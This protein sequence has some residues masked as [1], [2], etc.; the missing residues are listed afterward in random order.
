MQDDYAI[1][2]LL[3]LKRESRYSLGKQKIDSMLP[4]QPA[5]VLLCQIVV[6]GNM[7]WF[8]M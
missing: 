7:F 2:E 5:F 8:L 3:M 4:R 6:E 1:N